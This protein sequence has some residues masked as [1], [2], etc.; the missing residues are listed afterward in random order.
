MILLG[1]RP[2]WRGQPF[3]TFRIL[4]NAA[5]YHGAVAEEQRGATAF[6]ARSTGPAGH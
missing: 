3:G 1:L 4:F 2:Q 6:Q 5:L